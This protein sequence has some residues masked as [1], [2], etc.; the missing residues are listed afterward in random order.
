[1]SSVYECRARVAGLKRHRP[2]DDPEVRAAVAELAV[3]R[4]ESQILRMFERID[5]PVLDE[6]TGGAA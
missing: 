1:V 4:L 2:A 6:V 3:A 5:T